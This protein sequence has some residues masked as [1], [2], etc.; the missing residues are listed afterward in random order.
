VEFPPAQ[1][2]ATHTGT[3]P[4]AGAFTEPAGLTFADPI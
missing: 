2:L 4:S 1:V 3:L